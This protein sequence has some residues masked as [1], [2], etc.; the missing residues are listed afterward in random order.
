MRKDVFILGV[1]MGISIFLLTNPLQAEEMNAMP[2]PEAAPAAA[3]PSE[4]A[5][6]EP[7]AEAPASAD[8][9]NY[10]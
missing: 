7:A 3:A 9:V 8:D 6:A 10:S 5:S 2:A 1:M 4:A